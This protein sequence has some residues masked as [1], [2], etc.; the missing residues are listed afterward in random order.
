[1]SSA[2]LQMR[3]RGRG[4]P[5]GGLRVKFTG[6]NFTTAAESLPAAASLGLFFFFPRSLEDATGSLRLCRKYQT[7][8]FFLPLFISK[9]NL[10]RF[11]DHIRIWYLATNKFLKSHRRARQSL[12]R[13]R[14]KR[15]FMQVILSIFLVL[16]KWLVGCFNQDTF[17]IILMR[18]LATIMSLGIKYS[19][20]FHFIFFSNISLDLFQK[21]N[22]LLNFFSYILF[23]TFEASLWWTWQTSLIFLTR[24]TLSFAPL[25]L[26][27]FVVIYRNLKTIT[28]SS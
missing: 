24:T 16:V 28:Q 13:G 23:L 1:M 2:R 5:T 12:Q 18:R 3:Q 8:F 17:W 9:W 25:C 6:L 7:T 19:S 21:L 11:R 10:R 26:G 20:V 27:L 14:L 22:I 4:R 15:I